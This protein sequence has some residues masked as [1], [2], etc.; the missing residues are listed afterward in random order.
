[1]RNWFS[2]QE[3]SPNQNPSPET[4]LEKSR[5]DSQSELAQA[6]LRELLQD[7]TVP[8]EVRNALSGEYAELG[9]L[10]QKLEQEE[11]HIAVFGRVSVGK[12]SLLNALMG[13]NYF[14]VS[15]LHGET[16]QKEQHKWKDLHEPV[17]QIV[18][19]QT[20]GVHFIDT[21]GIDEVEGEGREV[22]A[23]KAAMRAD[24]ILFVID[25][26]LTQI[27]FQ[28]LQ[29]LKQYSQPL[30]LILNKSDHFTEDEQVRL[31][32]HLRERTKDLVDSENILLTRSKAS[33]KNILIEN[34]D[35]TQEQRIDSILP[36]VSDLKN[37]IWHIVENDGR[38]LAALN[39][40]LFASDL[41][42][43]VGRQVLA[44]RRE[45]ANK[46]ITNYSLTKGLA[47]AVNPVPVA[48]LLAAAGLDV[49]MI[50]HLSRLHGL[51]MSKDEASSLLKVIATQLAALMGTAWAI[52]ALSSALKATTAGLS[53][54]FTAAAQGSIGYYATVVLGRV[55]E[56]WLAQGKSWGQHGPKA[57]V[58]N[59]LNDLDRNSIIQ[60]G[61]TAILEKLGR[62]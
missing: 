16:K 26:D 53:T 15:P 32:Q 51:P 37:R 62:S 11:I 2:K 50:I 59:I 25:G 48:D 23:R 60:E 13:E 17:D 4:D 29:S 5:V 3:T 61:R 41:S 10:L 30:L 56:A 1:M 49:S 27:E 47:V 18:E 44:L 58:K 21:P 6:S 28:A 20:G 8:E 42:D 57:V 24:I 9:K 43:D 46:V 7:P 14:S 52:H 40:S 54:F 22:I 19:H 36:E 39:A 38:T 31:M 35:G 12:S 34:P 55:A 45:L 33:H